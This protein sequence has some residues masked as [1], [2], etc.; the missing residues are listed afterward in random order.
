M[1]REQIRDAAMQRDASASAR[2]AKR[3]VESTAQG[4]SPSDRHWQRIAR[5]MFDQGHEE[6]AVMDALR[7]KGAKTYMA[8]D[9][10][11]A[12]RHHFRNVH[13]MA[14][15][16]DGLKGLVAGAAMCLVGA[17]I[18][19]LAHLL[20]AGIGLVFAG[21]PLMVFGAYKLLTGSSIPLVLPEDLG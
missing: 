1:N 12:T 19:L 13:H 2:Y 3:V 4:S 18:V 8:A 20:F 5:T 15:R 7:E 21:L 16:K 9:A 6:R 14:H 17:A 11:A 10:C